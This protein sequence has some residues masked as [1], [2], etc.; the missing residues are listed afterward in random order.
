[1][2][3]LLVRHLISY[4]TRKAN[5]RSFDISEVNPL[6]DENGRTVKLAAYLV[7]EAMD[8]FADKVTEKE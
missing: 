7:A 4:I 1:L 6:L 8:G 3:P 5:I 2:D